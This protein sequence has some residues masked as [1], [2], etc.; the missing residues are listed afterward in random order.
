MKKRTVIAI[1]VAIFVVTTAAGATVAFGSSGGHSYRTAIATTATVHEELAKSGTIEPVAQAS[2]GFP[3]SGTVM[4]VNVTLG[5]S[6]TT[7]QRL[8]RLDTTSLQKDLTDKQ[9]TLAQS[10]LTLYKAMHGESVGSG[11]V[12]STGGASSAI[13]TASYAASAASTSIVLAAARTTAPSSALQ[14][15][16]QAVLAAQKKV[17]AALAKAKLSLQAAT[18]ACAST[19]TTSTTSTTAPTTSTTVPATGPGTTACITAQQQVASDQQAVAKAQAG[20]AKAETALT[21]LLASASATT[22]STTPSNPSPSTTPLGSSRSGS[23]SSSS[24]TSSSPTAEQLVAYQAAVDAAAAEVTAALQTLAQATIVSPISGTVA[25][26]NLAS[27]DSVSA[28]SSTANIVVVGTHGYEVTTTVTVDEVA[29]VKVGD[30]ATVVADG[31]STKRAAKVVGVGVAPSSN[32]STTTYPVVVGLT[33]AATGLRNGATAA[34]TIEIAHSSSAAVTVPTSAV[35]TTNGFH[36]VT[37]LAN[38]K[39]SD[40]RITIGAVGSEITE[41]KSGLKAGQVVVL[42]D[43]SAALPA[44]NTNNRFVRGGFGSSLSGGGGGFGGFGGGGGFGG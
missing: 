41:V 29:K 43:M 15:A 21:K 33:G 24:S 18:T 4:S 38:G 14:A 17:D 9:A 28:S 13:S 39:T 30:T 27:G 5:Q 11:A 10:Q 42:A 32:G 22:P 16:Q 34:V 7:G 25:A 35:H 2:V 12:G 37:V 26:V 6:V 1:V 40:V 44:S 19:T 23:T 36:F 31:T 3:I 8:A 20:L